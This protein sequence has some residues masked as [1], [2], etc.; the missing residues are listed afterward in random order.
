MLVVHRQKARI[1]AGC[2]HMAVKRIFFTRQ[3][4]DFA[5]FVVLLAVYFTL[6]FISFEHL[7]K[8]TNDAMLAIARV[9]L[10]NF[11]LSN[12]SCCKSSIPRNKN[13][14]LCEFS[15]RFFCNQHMLL[16]QLQDFRT[17][18]NIGDD[19][20]NMTARVVDEKAIEYC[21]SAS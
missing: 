15:I 4:V 10:K 12:K 20:C 1:A 16:L 14:A 2:L 7:Q 21:E 6:S 19:D 3:R 8:Q 18:L 5:I 11:S 9:F 17:R 13:S